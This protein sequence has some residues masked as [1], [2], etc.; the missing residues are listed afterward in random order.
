MK[1]TQSTEQWKRLTGTSMIFP[2]LFGMSR[3]ENETVNLIFV[4][5]ET[6]SDGGSSVLK[7]RL[8]QTVC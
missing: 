7:E 8:V 6:E 1:A 5:L 4:I 3:R 2:G